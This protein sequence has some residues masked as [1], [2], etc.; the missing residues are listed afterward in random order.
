MKNEKKVSS[1]ELYEKAD[2]FFETGNFLEAGRY[3]KSTLNSNPTE[4]IK[5]KTLS[6]LKKLKIDHVELFIGLGGFLLL[7]TLYVYFGF[8]R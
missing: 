8:I 4:D 6:M 5:S 7:S 2:G 1:K 3:L